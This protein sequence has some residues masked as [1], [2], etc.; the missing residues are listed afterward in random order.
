[1]RPS[2]RPALRASRMPPPSLDLTRGARWAIR[3]P[4]CHQW[5]SLRRSAVT[6]HEDDASASGWCPGSHRRVDVDLTPDEWRRRLDR[7]LDPALVRPASGPVGAPAPPPS[8]AV[9]QLAAT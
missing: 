5:W 3:C 1:M 7:K 6:R 2:L 9:C 4:D 8:P